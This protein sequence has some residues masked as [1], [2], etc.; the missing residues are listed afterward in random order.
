[1][2]WLFLPV[3]V[4][5]T[6]CGLPPPLSVIM[7]EAVRVPVAV[8]VNVTLIVQLAWAP[9]LPPQVLVSAKSPG[10]A[11]LRLMLVIVIA[12]T[13]SLLVNVTVW[14]ALVDPT[15]WL[16]K[17]RLV[18]V[19]VMSV[20]T[21]VSATVCG[22]PEALSVIDRVAVRLFLLVGRKGHTDGAICP[23][24]HARSAGVRLREISALR[25]RDA[26]GC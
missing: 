2:L 15:A 24:R 11:P 14:A 13:A 16:P 17:V 20:P 10:F 8:G 7:T 19:S 18:G 4:R 12:C 25:A 9:T 26:R 23:R 1:M 6:D 21:P 22:L 3:P 5:P